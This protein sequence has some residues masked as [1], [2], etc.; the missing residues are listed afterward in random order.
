[1]EN[2]MKKICFSLILFIIITFAFTSIVNGKYQRDVQENE[3]IS[4]LSEFNQLF[5]PIVIKSQGYFVAPFGSDTNPGTYQLPWKTIGKAARTI[6]A[7]DIVYIREGIYH[8]AVRIEVSGT[9]LKPIRIMAY[10]GENPVID[11]GDTIPEYGGSLLNI[12]GDYIYASGIE[13]RNSFYI[14]IGVYGNYDMV[15]DMYVHHNLGPGIFISHGR[16]SIV[17]NS[18]VWK[19]GLSS[20]YG[21]EDGQTGL[22]A[23]RD[24]VSYATIRHNIVWETWG[25]G[26][27]TF[28]ADHT[29][30]EDNI[31]HDSYT[32]NIYISDATNVLCQRNFVYTDPTSY[33]YPYGPHVGIALGDELYTPPSANITVINN[34]AFGNHRNFFWWQGHQGGGMNNVLIANNTFVNGIGDP[35]DGNANVIIDRGDHVNVRFMNNL[36]QQDDELPVIDTINQPGV[37]YSNNLWSK[38]P[39]PDALGPGDVISDPLL[40]KNGTPYFPDWFYLQEFSPAIG[41]ATSLPEVRLDY[42]GNLRDSYPDMGAIEYFPTP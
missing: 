19:N 34:I 5:L 18:Y 24:G 1:M 39:D 30:I 17:Q 38:A 3:Q 26:I 28:E 41:R 9:D 16:Y 15:D 40:V 8:E 37:V 27:S 6:V 2:N 25:E 7:G 23:A 31:V 42:L 4:T 14:G 32:V 11:G 33:V 36:V 13:V 35:S 10:Q 22:S 29:V 21:R 12:I 20:E